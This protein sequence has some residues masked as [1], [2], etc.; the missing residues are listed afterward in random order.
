ME[1]LNLEKY[2]YNNVPL[3]IVYKQIIRF[4]KEKG[5]Y[6]IY[7]KSAYQKV[8]SYEIF[9]K[10]IRYHGDSIIRNFFLHRC[11][12]GS[13]NED[14]DVFSL[15]LK[16]YI[17]STNILCDIHFGLIDHLNNIYDSWK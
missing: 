8:I 2:T 13:K 5:I 10:N 9:L 12:I 15:E 14:Y 16:K 7:M 1:G 3:S 17:H 4:M 6:T 11:N